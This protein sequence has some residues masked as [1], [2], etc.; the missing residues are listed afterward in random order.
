MLGHVKFSDAISSI[1]PRWRSSSRP[2]SSA[3]SGSISASPAVLSCS[4]VSWA[5]AIAPD[6]KRSVGEGGPDALDRL[7][8]R[9]RARA[10]HAW[11]LAREVDHGGRRP[12]QRPEV[13]DGG[14]GCPNARGYVLHRG[15]ARP[16]GVVRARREDGPRV[17]DDASRLLSELGH[18]PPDPPCPRP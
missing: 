11:L 3:I 5:T 16:A 4:R 1:W 17:L 2:S 15:R 10:D 6:G 8:R 14:A 13:D 7:R 9:R 18:A 12:G